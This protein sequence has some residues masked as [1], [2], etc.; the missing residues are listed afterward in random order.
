M[1]IS[2]ELKHYDLEKNYWWFE[3]RRDI[4]FKLIKDSNINKKSKIL[5]IGC[6][7]GHLIRFLRNKGFINIFGIDNSE[8]SVKIC[9]K[10]KIVLQKT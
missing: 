3:A 10:R 7:G 5:D 1:D 6:A 9:K 2:Y 4:I 8:R